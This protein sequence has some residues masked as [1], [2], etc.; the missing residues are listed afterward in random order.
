MKKSCLIV[1]GLLLIAGPAGAATIAS[2]EQ[3]ATHQENVLVPPMRVTELFTTPAVERIMHP[4]RFAQADRPVQRDRFAGGAGYIETSLE[5]DSKERPVGL[6]MSA[7][8]DVVPGRQLRDMLENSDVI[9]A[10]K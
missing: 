8:S 9:V 4:T 2:T 5:A 1:L 7:Y 3:G 6:G 10:L